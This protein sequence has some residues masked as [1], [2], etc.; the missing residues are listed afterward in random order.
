MITSRVRNAENSSLKSKRI[1]IFSIAQD[2][3]KAYGN[4][5]QILIP[6]LIL[7]LAIFLVHELSNFILPYLQ[8]TATNVIWSLIA[9]LLQLGIL[10]YCFS[11]ILA[12]STKITYEHKKS[13]NQI[14]TIAHKCTPTMFGLLLFTL[15]IFIL[16]NTLVLTAGKFA[17]AF[18]ASFALTTVIAIWIIGFFGC[19]IFL[20]FANVLC[21]IENLKFFASIRTSAHIVTKNYLIVSLLSII[22]FTII[23]LIDRFI[24]EFLAELIKSLIL[25]PY[26][27]LFLVYFIK[28]VRKSGLHTG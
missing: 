21:V 13:F 2:A 10:A 12:L 15:I 7:L 23:Y 6:A 27:A 28:Q 3:F 22:L 8:T 11:A 16:L 26:L 25:F 5:P 1:N 9:T 4:N 17:L 20:A 24:S 19:I 14:F 18:N